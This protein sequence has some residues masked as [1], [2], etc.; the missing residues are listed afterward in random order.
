MQLIRAMPVASFV[1]LAL[2]WVRS[3]NAVGHCQLYPVLPVVYAGVLGG[4]ADTDPKLLEMAKVYR[5]PLSA[6]LRYIWL[7]G[8]F[9]SFCESCIAAMGMC[10]KSGVSAEV[11]GLPDHSVGDALYRAKITLSTPDVLRGRWLSCCCR[12]RCPRQRLGPA[13]GQN[14][15]FAGGA[16]VSIEITDLCKSFGSTPVLQAFTWT[17]DRPMV[18][19]GRSG[20]GSKTTLL[21]ILLG[22]ESADSGTVT[23]VETPAAVFQEDRLCPQL[24]AAV[25]L[26]LTGHGLSP[27]DAR[28]GAAYPWLYRCRAGF[29]RC[30]ALR[31]AEAPRPAARAALPRC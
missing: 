24:T 27:Q 7:P 28:A 2:L 21:R 4:I 6:R 12:R 14:P 11:I 22:L 17:V 25:N 19:M 13:R 5:L 15:P 26:T 9:P 1:I 10:W 30:A 3:A 8:V 18:L 20:C 29:A 31:R 23:G 16:R